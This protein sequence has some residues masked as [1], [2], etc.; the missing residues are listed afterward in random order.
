M[1]VISIERW[2]STW[3]SNHG[4]REGEDVPLP[5]VVAMMR[6]VV[7]ADEEMIESY[8]KVIEDLPQRATRDIMQ[9]AMG[10]NPQRGE[11][12]YR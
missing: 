7:N 12:S 6:Q 3:L 5:L 9:E 8:R 2:V 11:R 10:G 1:K 4:W